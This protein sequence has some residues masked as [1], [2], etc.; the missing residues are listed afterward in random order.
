MSSNQTESELP[1]LLEQ[2][3]L[4]ELRDICR[5][6]A[7]QIRGNSKAD[8]ITAMVPL[9]RDPTQVARAVIALSAPLREAL[10]AAF[11]VEDGN[12]VT[13]VAM[14]R[15]ISAWHRDPSRAVKPVEAAGLLLDL[16]RWGLVLPWRSSSGGARYL[17]PWELQRVVPALPGWCPRL[18]SVP[19][20]QVRAIHPGQC[21]LVLHNT[22]EAIRQH[23]PTVRSVLQ[24]PA[25]KQAARLV[26]D[27]PYDPAELEPLLAR[28][29][30][31]TRDLPQTL[32]LPTPAYLLDD[33]SLESLL[34]LTSGDKEQL[35]FVCRL[36]SELELVGCRDGHLV[37]RQDVMAR[38][39][40]DPAAERYQAITRAY[41]SLQ[42][43][44]ELDIL[45]RADSHLILQRSVHTPLSF[46]HFRSQLVSVRQML[47]RFLAA[48]S[49]ESWCYL[50][51]IDA[52]LELLWRSF[53]PIHEEEER[54][55]RPALQAW[56]L[57]WRERQPVPG[58]FPSDKMRSAQSIH[59]GNA[60]TMA[61]SEDNDPPG[62]HAAQGAMWRLIV[63]KPLNWLGLAE[64][65]QQGQEVA[66]FRL[67]GLTD[68]IWDRPV[69]PAMDRRN[70]TRGSQK[71]PSAITWSDS[72]LI[73]HVQPALVSL[74]ALTFLGTI[75][76]LEQ[77]SA[78]G[79]TYRL[80]MD[81][82]YKAFVEGRSLSDLLAEWEDLIALPMPDSIRTALTNWWDSYGRV[83]L[84]GGLALLELRD[85]TTLRELEAS[86]ALGKY[87]LARLSGRMVIVPENRVDDLLREFMA[88]G[89]TPKEV[90]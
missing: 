83:H 39:R 49:Q 14:A 46:G 53:Y 42:D 3:R 90:E 31:R 51:D 56:R 79:F 48:A 6:R 80:S 76:D 13:P 55:A 7:W 81:Q 43:W 54:L 33:R 58:P 17:F 26:Q 38:F 85:S 69:L 73:I 37:A 16:A 32:S 50:S 23:A 86:T 65:C 18:P 36:L 47:L 28:H 8:Y 30:W 2:M 4:G 70:S 72:D 35:E 19:L 75:G 60:N 1:V 11:V 87:T 45:L 41:L 15:V 66:A 52:S 44:S 5:Q 24:A 68:L 29:G 61:T 25:E 71:S 77:A 21:L 62:W 74:S 63:Q 67:C 88:R 9:L 22:W 64:L 12:G 40:A 84:Y 89:H 82:V 27:W 78:Q 57:A 20:G 34:P 10:Q 59:N